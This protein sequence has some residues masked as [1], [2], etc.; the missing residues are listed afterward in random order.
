MGTQYRSVIFYHSEE[1]K[2]LAQ[3]YKAELDSSGA[4]PAPIVTKSRSASSTRPSYHQ[5]TTTRTRV[6]AIA[7]WS[8]RPKMEKFEGL[9]EAEGEKP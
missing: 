1:Q 7:G 9:C 4:F 6:R 5:I 2:K 3:Q 8:S